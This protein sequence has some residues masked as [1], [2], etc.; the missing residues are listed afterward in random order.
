MN[1]IVQTKRI[2]PEERAKIWN[3]VTRKTLAT[4][5]ITSESIYSITSKITTTRKRSHFLF[6]PKITQISADCFVLNLQEPV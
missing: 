2:L 1:A 4:G 3:Q 5:M 6:Y